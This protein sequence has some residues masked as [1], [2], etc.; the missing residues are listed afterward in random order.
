ARYIIG[1][2]WRVYWSYE[3][4]ARE[5]QATGVGSKIKDIFKT[6]IHFFTKTRWKR[7][8]KKY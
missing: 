4:T 6:I 5:Y 1:T 8:F 7:T 2:P 3:G